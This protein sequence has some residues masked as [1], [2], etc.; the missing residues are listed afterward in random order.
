MAEWY[1]EGFGCIHRGWAAAGAGAARVRRRRSRCPACSL[2][3]CV[4]RRSGRGARTAHPRWSRACRLSG[5]RADGTDVGGGAAR[6]GMRRRC[7]ATL[8]RARARARSTS[9]R[10]TPTAAPS[11]PT[12]C[13]STSA[14]RFVVRA[15]R[16]CA[17]HPLESVISLRCAPTL[18]PLHA[19]EKNGRAGAIHAAALAPQRAGRAAGALHVPAAADGPG[20]R[21]QARARARRRPRRRRPGRARGQARARAQTHAVCMDRRCAAPLGTV[22]RRHTMAGWSACG[23]QTRLLSRDHLGLLECPG[24]SLT[25]GWPAPLTIGP[26]RQAPPQTLCS[27]P[28]HH[29]TRSRMSPQRLVGSLWRGSPSVGVCGALPNSTGSDLSRVPCCSPG[30]PAAGLATQGRAPG[31]PAAGLGR[32]PGRRCGVLA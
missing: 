11:T 1:P 9:G 27:M 20:A 13:A 29:S 24:G 15:S 2:R 31:R 30:G 12:T 28:G 25:C 18:S 26:Y 21:G 7:R 5:G 6:R 16:R 14:R 23:L 8:R 4:R 32:G 19:T 22:S 10:R 3:R 17:L